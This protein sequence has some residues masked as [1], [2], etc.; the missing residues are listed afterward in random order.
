[1]LVMK[2]LVGLI[3]VQLLLAQLI[4]ADEA[5]P[6][7]MEFQIT[8]PDSAWTLQSGPAKEVD[9]EIWMVW[10]LS[11]PANAIGA[12]VITTLKRRYS[13]AQP[14]AWAGKTVKHFVT[15]KTWGWENKEE[16]TFIKDIQELGKDF[17]QAKS[18]E[19]AVVGEKASNDCNQTR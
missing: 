2:H 14:A 15:G 13:P 19:H 9:G 5:Q 6:L 10:H 4:S 3:L 11:R 8:V 17:Q 7:E 18:L 16:L 12:Q 1:M